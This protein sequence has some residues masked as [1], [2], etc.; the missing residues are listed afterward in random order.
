MRPVKLVMSAFGPYAKET[1][2]DFDKLGKSGLYLITGDTGAGKTT[3]FDALTFALYGEASGKDRK[4]DMLRSK[5]A[6]KDT[7]TEVVLD[8]SYGGETYRVRRN[9]KYTRPAR[10]GD[11]E[12][13]CAPG[14][15]LT[16]PDGRVLTKKGEVDA[17]IRQIMGIDYGQF[18]QI[19]MIAQGDFLE[20]LLAPTEDRQ[21]IFRDIFQTRYYLDLQKRLK[22]EE[23]KLKQDCE[24]AQRSIGQYISG[25][26]CDED[27]R[28]APEL[29]KAKDGALTIEDTLALLDRLLADDQAELDALNASEKD[30]KAR[31]EE[32]NQKLGKAE[33]AEKTADKLKRAEKEC[34]VGKER[35]KELSG[36]YE[37]EIARRPEGDRMG[38]LA[39][40]LEALFPKY[41]SRDK[42][43]EK[44]K[45]LL[46]QR[47]REAVAAGEAREKLKRL[48]Q[49]LSERKD[50]RS[51][52]EQAGEQKARLEAELAKSNARVAELAELKR[53]I[54]EQAK[55]KK[56]LEAAQD[57]YRAAKDKAEQ[58]RRA[59]DEMDRAFLDEQAGILARTR[60][61][62]GSP[63][64]VCGSVEHPHPATLSEKAPSE[65]QRK[66]ARKQA[67]KDQADREEASRAAGA[68]RARAEEA[69]R[70]L[71]EKAKKLLETE[72]DWEAA[73][74]RELADAR[75][76]I[77]KLGKDLEEEE[78]KLTRRK[79]LDEHL[80]PADEQ[81][82]GK[83]DDSIRKWENQA[84]ALQSGL[85]ETERQL[86]DYAAELKYPDKQAAERECRRLREEQAGIRSALEKAEQAFRAQETRCTELEGQIKQLREQLE[87][88]ERADRE[89]LASEKADLDGKL[90]ELDG[91]Q[92]NLHTRQHTNRRA[93]D[94]IRGSG[95]KLDELKKKYGW[96]KAMSET[97]NG[98]LSGKEK[99]ELETYVQMT[100][101]DRIIARA[102]TRFLVMSGGQYELV[103][104]RT[105]DNMRSKS[106]LELD[107][108]D[109][110]NGTQRS[111]NTLSGG[112]SFKASLSLALGLSDEVQ[113]SAG[114]VRIDTMFVDEGFGSLD[115]ESLAQAIKA[116][117]GLTESNRLVGIISHVSELKDKIDRQIV[118]TKERSGGSRVDIV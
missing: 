28:F 56:Q 9:P 65:N 73:A 36:K 25:A 102:N 71:R 100:W 7:P 11:G 30:L 27:S 117:S 40:A 20:L 18:S 113:S 10:R 86:K 58:S 107:V 1:E 22:E 82:R 108:V 104:R 85:D 116:L 42:L 98:G 23:G 4:P 26:V 115:A 59:Y 35:L 32:V 74:E 47:D 33:D 51:R 81:E 46:D 3:I 66:Q 53:G 45:N 90:T 68:L 39:A 29:Q 87:G 24:S 95:E 76:Q 99:I 5:Y 77:Q 69:E 70:L 72:D 97:A 103:R 63:C 83:L 38:E 114:G 12:V 14:A 91:K 15:E 118:V 96:V 79:D 105:A 110:Y 6:G 94:N 16:M 31:L 44:R 37:A 48:D 54:G 109:H 43:A 62:A 50:E 2:V 112:E 67:E 106:G 111:V 8:F 80:I 88:K 19:A 93:R 84:A 34:G 89:R 57:K 41:D 60:L 13:V 17:A 101:F 75:E 64:P 78:R 21:K 92:K 61:A 52:L 55:R 49:R